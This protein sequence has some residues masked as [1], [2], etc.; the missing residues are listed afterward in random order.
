MA[1]ISSKSLNGVAENK[2]GFN[3]NELQN[4]EFSDGS[5]LDAYDFNA[6]S[7]DQQVGRFLQIDPLLE[8][9]DQEVLSP[10]HFAYN[11]PIR[12][13]DPDGKCPSC[14]IGGIIGFA[15]EYGTQA[16]VNRL[17]GK[18]WSESLTNVNGGQLLI[19]TG[20]GVVSGGFSALTPK[21]TI[22]KGLAKGGE[23][24]VSAT[25]SAAKQYNSDS[26]IDGMKVLTD[27]G[28][29]VVGNALTKNVKINS[30]STIK[31]TEKQLDRAKRVAVDDPTSTG[32]NAMVEKI[33]SKLSS[34]NAAN[35]GVR[36]AS[37]GAVSNA[38]QSSVDAVRNYNSA[39]TLMRIQNIRK[40]VG[41]NTAVKKPLIY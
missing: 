1:G 13:S 25:E 22:A 21:T 34:Q 41:D 15:V 18:S 31:T 30:S 24:L 12:Y 16:V 35:Q 5:G 20:A 7:Y 14:I 38:M 11:N 29:G 3:G 9:S 19:A 33:K 26:K 37:S 10:Y 32:R 17:E 36:Q 4:K 23:L 40:S 8:A 6:R 28:S 27:V 2:R 39:N